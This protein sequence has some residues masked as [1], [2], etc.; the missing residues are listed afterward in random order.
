VLVQE[1]A[2]IADD[3]ANSKQSEAVLCSLCI[4]AANA[5]DDT[6]KIGDGT[7][8]TA[9]TVDDTATIGDGGATTAD[10]TGTIGND[11]GSVDVLVHIVESHTA[12]CYHVT[13]DC[14]GLRKKSTFNPL[15]LTTIKE[16]IALGYR[17]CDSKGGTYNDRF[18]RGCRELW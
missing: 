13:S 4:G 15:S 9:D 6:A 16:A 10:D 8:K 12:I 5:A 3:E 14:F 2:S 18:L 17:R 11:E 7:A 1:S